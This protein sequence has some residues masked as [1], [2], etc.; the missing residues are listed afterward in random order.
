[1]HKGENKSKIDRKVV[2]NNKKLG[3]SKVGREM[4]FDNKKSII[5]LLKK[6]IKI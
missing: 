5:I 6:I 2:F 3:K 4:V 1:M